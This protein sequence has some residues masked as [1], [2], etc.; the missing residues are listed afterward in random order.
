MREDWNQRA[1]EDAGYYV[2][3][4]RRDQDDEEFFETAKEVVASV[5]WELRRFPRNANR[6]AWR[7]LEIGCGPGRLMRPLSRH[8]GEIHGVDVSDEMIRL[9]RGKL[10]G[11]P[12]AHVHHGD[13]ASLAAFAD[14]SFDMV[15]SYAVFQHIPSRDVV[16]QYLR[17]ARR[18]LKTGGLM[19]AQFNGLPQI[20]GQ[21]DTWSGVRFSPEELMEFTRQFD[22]QVLALE[23]AGT[24]YMWTSWRKRPSGRHAH[25]LAGIAPKIRV[26]HITNAHSSEPVAPSSGRF[27]SISIWVED[28]PEECG[29]HDLEV[30]LA[31]LRG[32]ITY[33]GPPDNS[34]IQQI[35]VI[36]PNLAERTGLVPV[37]V[38]WFGK[39]LLSKQA[40]L[41]VIPPGPPVPRVVAVSDGV[42]LLS[43]PT[44]QSRTVKVTFE[45]IAYPGEFSVT[46][47]GRTITDQEIFCTN[48]L[49]Q[50]FEM[51]LRL[52]EA[53][54]AGRHELWIYSGK[55]RF[56]P[57]SIEVL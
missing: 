45:E 15:Y 53:T 39:S 32:S 17:E 9:A 36:L 14:E 2:A 50:R 38:L 19:R 13:G 26:R 42:N 51:N 48:P 33:I 8:F 54:A 16:M 52:P 30:I 11:I 3:F 12:H 41:R 18:V 6:R 5:E 55:R 46:L 10:A 40:T 23:G 47:D 22:F 20:A 49:S 37:D 4:G 28:L 29:L 25:P 7:A 56:G 24:Q 31:G 1:R 44:I 34:G 21:Y 57:I 43:G 35:N 27:A